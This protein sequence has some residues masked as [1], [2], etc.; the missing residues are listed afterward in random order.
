MDSISSEPNEN[1]PGRWHCHFL[2]LKRR[3]LEGKRDG[4]P[5]H[6]RK[7]DNVKVNEKVNLHGKGARLVALSVHG[8]VKP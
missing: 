4:H 2:T 1:V 3:W 6:K 8:E 7:S 5:G